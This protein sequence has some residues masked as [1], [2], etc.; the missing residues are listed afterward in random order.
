MH[1]RLFILLFSALAILLSSC[2]QEVIR[3]N[4]RSDL[5]YQPAA[6][7]TAGCSKVDITPS[8]GYP[9]GGF[10]F[11]GKYPRGFWARLYATSFCFQD[12]AG[13]VLI[14]VSCDLWSMPAGLADKVVEQLQMMAGDDPFIKHLGREQI[15]FSATHTHNSQ[16]NYSTSSSYNL[17]ASIGMGF[18]QEMFHFLVDRI[19]QSIIGAVKNR[20]PASL[21]FKQ[22][23][24][25]GISRNRSMEAFEANPENSSI[26]SINKRIYQT[27]HSGVNTDPDSNKYFSVNPTLSVIMIVD[28]ADRPRGIAGFY[29]VHPTAMGPET[30]VYSSDIF[31]VACRAV[32]QKVSETYGTG[33]C[34]AAMF[35]GAEGDVSPDWK[36]QDRA[37]TMT[38]GT[39]LAAGILQA[40]ETGDRIPPPKIEFRYEEVNIV[41]KAVGIAHEDFPSCIEP[42]N[43]RTAKVPSPGMPTLGGAEDGRTFLYNLGVREG[44][45]ATDSKE[46]RDDPAQGNKLRVT[47][48]RVDN[49]LGNHETVLRTITRIALGQFLSSS[50]VN[51]I[52][53]GVYRFGNILLGTLPGE[54]TTTL[55]YRISAGLK[56]NH[57]QDSIILIGLANEYLS[58]FTTPGEYCAQHYEGASTLYGI[59]AGSFVE[60]NLTRISRLPENT[61]LYDH[62]KK[63]NCG[64]A[65]IG[66]GSSH[67][68][69]DSLWRMDEGLKNLIGHENSIG[70]PE[71]YVVLTWSDTLH[72]PMMDAL[73]G[74][75]VTPAVS[76]LR[77]AW[78]AVRSDSIWVPLKIRMNGPKDE[79]DQNTVDFVTVLE[80]IMSQDNAR[81][82]HWRT[83]WFLPPWLDQNGMYRFMVKRRF[84]EPVLLTPPLSKK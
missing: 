24:L 43:L 47:N 75:N 45:T 33:E 32:E 61:A 53:L 13:H 56:S 27:V 67:I 16:A 12:T 37:N 39:K 57:P 40:V 28:S 41:D 70:L 54:F 17:L 8:P 23:P 19:S 55:G 35:N 15:I 25:H 63:Y 10:G 50:S 71:G 59:G 82:F 58:Y 44:M 22:I 74:T 21:R 72:P 52:P 26:Q 68:T 77:K 66:I 81:I 4:L 73:N 84:G 46:N 7:F 30:E 20:R 2:S 79:D 36:I 42:G 49:L 65:A 62:S 64:S 18:N 78:D 31:G 5:Q 51:T 38:I 29:A 14:L 69:E 48:Y 9:M 11:D 60:E 3:V 1:R 6:F 80:R 34:V 76:V 83:I